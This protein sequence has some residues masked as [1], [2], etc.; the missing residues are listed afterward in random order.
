MLGQYAAIGS[1]SSDNR[2]FVY[3]I[4]GLSQNDQTDGQKSAIRSSDNQFIQVPAYRMNETMQRIT[5]MGGKI[6]SIRPIGEHVRSAAPAPEAQAENHSEG[7]PEES[8]K[9]KRR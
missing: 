7:A 5:K 2:I 9:R 6:A 4:A 3:E 1:S 8:S